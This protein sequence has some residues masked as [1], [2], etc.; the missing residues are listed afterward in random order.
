MPGGKCVQLCSR[1]TYSSP[2]TASTPSSHLPVHH[3]LPALQKSPILFFSFSIFTSLYP[4]IPHLLLT[5]PPHTHPSLTVLQGITRAVIS[6]SCS[7]SLSFSDS[8]HYPYLARPWRHY[9]PQI[10]PSS[11]AG[12]VA[13]TQRSHALSRTHRRG[14]GV[15]CVHVGNE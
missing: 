9:S 8:A 6:P 5:S 10:T 4:P 3:V 2:S 15:W 11:R 1:N 7:L 12:R 14:R 13:A